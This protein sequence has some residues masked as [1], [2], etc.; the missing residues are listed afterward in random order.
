MRIQVNSDKTITVD[1]RV[2]S[3]VDSEVKRSLGRFEDRLTRVEV[4]LSDVNSYKRGS[5][6]K[7]CMVEARPAG[8]QPLAV[9][10]AAARVDAA[11]RGALSKLRRALEAAFGRAG[12]QTRVAG[13]ESTLARQTRGSKSGSEL[14]VHA[15]EAPAGV[16]AGAAKQ[17]T[18][19]VFAAGATGAEPATEAGSPKRKA[20]YQARRKSWPKR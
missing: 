10:M 13:G 6:D 12:K 1:S 15:S 5:R 17:A 9:T 19:K 3:F 20:I 18:P 8:A 4:H 7:R 16:D 14:P 2:I 11:V